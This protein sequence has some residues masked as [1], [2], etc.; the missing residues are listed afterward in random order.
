MFWMQN[1]VEA[2]GG[3]L[4]RV[5]FLWG[6]AMSI[7][8]RSAGEQSAW[9]NL[10]L[11]GVPICIRRDPPVLARLLR[12]PCSAPV[13]TQARCKDGEIAVKRY[14]PKPKDTLRPRLR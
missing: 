12:G 4:L 11:T 9:L 10:E 7:D 2:K 8:S 13:H 5:L 6:H 1:A 3:R 14:I